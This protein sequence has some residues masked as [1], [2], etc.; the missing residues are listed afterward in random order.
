MT[1]RPESKTNSRPSTAQAT[2]AKIEAAQSVSIDDETRNWNFDNFHRVINEMSAESTSVSSI[3][4]AMVYQ[5]E[6]QNKQA[7]SSTSSQEQTERKTSLF[8]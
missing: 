8:G 3:M 1:P 4:A 7:H 2:Q 5:I 6:E